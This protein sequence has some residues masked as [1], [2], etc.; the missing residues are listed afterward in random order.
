MKNS[1][2]LSNNSANFLLL[3]KAFVN[4]KRA[5]E[6][7]AYLSLNIFWILS[8]NAVLIAIKNVFGKKN[9]IHF[10]GS[11]S[12]FKVSLNIYD[13]SSPNAF[14]GEKVLVLSFKQCF[15]ANIEKNLHI[16]FSS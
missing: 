6:Q 9:L 13:A 2:D 11:S 3:G 8:L 10:H 4:Q 1:S 12:T 15:E 7:F 14:Y 5:N 16:R